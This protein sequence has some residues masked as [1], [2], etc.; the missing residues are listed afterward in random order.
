MS[1]TFSR[2][3]NSLV[4]RW[5]WTVDRWVLA[6][7]IGIAAIGAV[8]ALA[9]TPA[10][11]ERLGFETF[12][13]A[14]RQFIFLPV[15][16][17]MMIGISLLT[18]SGVRRFAVVVLA[19]G[20]VL[21]LA[22]LFFGNEVKG[23]SR[24]LRLGGISLQPSEFVKASFPVVAAWLFA[25]RSLD[26]TFPGHAL[27]AG[28]FAL[29]AGLMLLQPD[30]GMTIVLSAVWGVQFFLAGMPMILVMI[31]GAIFIGGGI[32]SYFAFD[33]VRSRIDRFLDP[34]AGD[35]Y[36]VSR[37][38]EA[39]MNGGMFGTGPGEG[40]VK[41][42][43]PDSH[44]DFIFAVAGEEFGLFACLLIIA[45]YAFVVLRG[46]SRMFQ[47]KDLYV[48]LAVVGLLVQFGL[49]AIINMASTV[50]LIPTKGMTLPF[51][52]YGGSSMLAVAIAMGMMLALTRW[53]P[54]GGP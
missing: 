50:H 20:L 44:A 10:V 6:A 17:A 36:Q 47:E 22:T 32:T 51:I 34:S 27:A 38:M 41:A 11:A 35:S 8:L 1:A 29:C 30:V 49:Q 12:Y 3:D 39:F 2:T 4:G 7:L 25:A 28:L 31:I 5:W 26:K 46:F 24:W 53:R 21:T 9:A 23:A 52:S 45:L 14:R 33:H 19:A 43:L 13:F 48:L 54:G 40:T 18:P 42:V 37:S 15:A 16:L